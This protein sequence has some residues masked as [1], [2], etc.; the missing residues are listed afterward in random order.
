ME[1]AVEDAAD[2]FRVAAEL[3]GDVGMLGSARH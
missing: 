3:A 2:G 1:R